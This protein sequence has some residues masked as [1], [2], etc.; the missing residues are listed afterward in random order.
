[1]VTIIFSLTFL[2]LNLGDYSRQCERQFRS[3]NEI[4]TVSE[5]PKNH[6]VVD[7]RNIF[8]V[9]VQRVRQLFELI[10]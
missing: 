9:L 5:R 6:S 1:M 10:D 2:L 4:K 3:M 7:F 8:I